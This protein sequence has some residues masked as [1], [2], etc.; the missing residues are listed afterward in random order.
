MVGIAKARRCY[1][2]KDLRCAAPPPS[3]DIL[4]LS[5]GAGQHPPCGRGR[6]HRGGLVSVQLGLRAQDLAGI[7]RA[8]DLHG[9][10]K[11]GPFQDD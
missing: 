1:K 11:R 6:G 5:P 2:H 3:T 7:Y 8:S 4:P 10:G 9:A